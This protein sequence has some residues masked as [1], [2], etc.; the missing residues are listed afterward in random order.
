MLYQTLCKKSPVISFFFVGAVSV[1]AVIARIIFAKHHVTLGHLFAIILQH[2]SILLLA[3]SGNFIMT[4]QKI[5]GVGDYNVLVCTT[6]ALLALSIS[7]QNSFLMLA[8]LIAMILIHRFGKLFNQQEG[9][10]EE[11]EIGVFSA[12]AALIS[13]VFLLLLIYSIV[14]LNQSKS[15]RGRDYLALLL[16]FLFVLACKVAFLFFTNQPYFIWPFGELELN[17]PAFRS[18]EWIEIVT[19][20]LLGTW[21][22]YHLLQYFGKADQLS[23][24]LRIFYRSIT[25]LFPA[26][27]VGYFISVSNISLLNFLLLCSPLF[28]FL[29]QLTAGK[30]KSG[31]K[32]NISLFLFL[33]VLLLRFFA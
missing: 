22:G 3:A 12:L 23:V 26:I 33:T 8:I 14:I 31:W 9:A 19:I 16:G 6:L 32:N 2:A 25:L 30:S 7:L 24:R 5:V 21:Y 13:P 11:F 17:I 27:F 15:N 18:L 29:S 20:L 1:S 28:I 10:I 4:R